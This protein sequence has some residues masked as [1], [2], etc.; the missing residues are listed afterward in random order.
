VFDTAKT[1]TSVD[2]MD[3]CSKKSELPSTP[4][5]LRALA[6]PSSIEAGIQITPRQTFKIDRRLGEER[7]AEIVARYEAGETAQA[8]ADE[9]G[10]ARSAL[11]SMLRSR[12]VVVR[13]GA[14]TDKQIEELG[15]AYSSG[16][17]IASLEADTGIPHGTIQRGL[18]MAGVEM[19][20]RGFQLKKSL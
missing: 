5:E 9:F 18:K 6:S 12:S 2:L 3:L 15:R 19:R 17:T 13:R 11:L 16:A 4:V 10:V 20:P 14:L 1:G 7:C 8:L